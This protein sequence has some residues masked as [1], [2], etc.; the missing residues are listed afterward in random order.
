MFRSR[1]KHVRAKPWGENDFG[2]FEEVKAGQC[3]WSIVDEQVGTEEAG[4]TN[5]YLIVHSMEARVG[6][7][8]KGCFQGNNV[9]VT[10]SS[11]PFSNWLLCIEWILSR[12]NKRPRGFRKVGSHSVSHT[13]NDFGLGSGCDRDGEK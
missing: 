12:Q 6:N 3:E 8:L 7:Q 9:V 2:M 4:D 10:R 11:E 1:G 13:R 5:R